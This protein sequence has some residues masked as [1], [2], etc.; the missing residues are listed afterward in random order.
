M[1]FIDRLRNVVFPIAPPHYDH[2]VSEYFISDLGRATALDQSVNRPAHVGRDIGKTFDKFFARH[3][4]I[5]KNPNEWGESSS[6]YEHKILEING[7]ALEMAK[8]NGAIVVSAKY[9]SIKS[10]LS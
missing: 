7:L 8:I 6:A 4:T 1:D 3:P 5:T 10:G 2:P 9:S